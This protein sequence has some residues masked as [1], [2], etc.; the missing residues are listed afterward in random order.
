[1]TIRFAL[2]L[3]AVRRRPDR[4]ILVA[5]IVIVILAA[6]SP[7]AA[8]LFRWSRLGRLIPQTGFEPSVSVVIGHPTDP[9]IVYAATL[10]STDNTNLVFRSADRGLTWQPASSGLPANMP[11][12]TG[13]NSLLIR[14]DAPNTLYAGLYRAGVWRSTDGGGNWSNATNGSIAANDTV[15][16]LDAKPGQPNLLYALTGT[17]LHVSLNGGAW[18]LRSSGLPD[19]NQTQFVDLAADPL[20]PGTVYIATN[21]SGIYRTENDGQAWDAANNGLPAGDLNVRGIAVSPLSG[22]VLISIAGHGLW[23]S[24]NRG[25]SWTRSDA[26]ITYNTTLSGNVGIPAFSPTISGLV[27]VYN[28]DGAFTSSSNGQTW[29]P[30]NEGFTGAETVTTVSLHAAA[31]A[32]YA[33]TSISG[34][35]SLTPPVGR[36][37]VPI[38]TR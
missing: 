24:D 34:V 37:F 25:T 31:N 36:A 29:A 12:N 26:G 13:I 38:V 23:R 16:A 5:L 14:Q 3:R 33:G 6:A 22:R 8:G 10:R 4:S 19:A 11:Q 35:W 17:G 28:N 15:N 9:N 32:V 2:T 7:A 18:Q 20:H 21:P 1:M 30:A 27:Y